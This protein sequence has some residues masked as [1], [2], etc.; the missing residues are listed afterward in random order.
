[1]KRSSF[2]KE[3]VYLQL[4]SFIGLVQAELNENEKQTNNNF[5]WQ[6]KENIKIETRAQ[7]NKKFYICNFY[8]CI[9]CSGTHYPERIYLH[10]G[11]LANYRGTNFSPHPS[12]L[13]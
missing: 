11:N 6:M 3:A 13:A 4:K 8:C 2:Q 7:C 12:L 9:L 1:M 10:F 5:G